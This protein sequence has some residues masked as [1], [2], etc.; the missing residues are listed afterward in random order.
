M[1]TAPHSFVLFFHTKSEILWA[2]DKTPATSHCCLYPCGNL[3]VPLWMFH[4]C[5]IP[6]TAPPLTK[7][8]RNSSL[9]SEEDSVAF[10]QLRCTTNRSK[11]TSVSVSAS[12]KS[13]SSDS[14]TPSQ[15]DALMQLMSPDGYYTYLGIEKIPVDA[16]STDDSTTNPLNSS[17]SSSW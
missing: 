16:N 11:F 12:F 6:N 3:S 17:S 13:M 9:S 10:P 8:N 15:Q 1:M 2:V 7:R 5:C 4:Q 14:T